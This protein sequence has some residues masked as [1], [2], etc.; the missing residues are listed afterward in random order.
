MANY[1]IGDLQ[2][3]DSAFGRL[4]GKIDFSP[5]RDTLFV[6]GDLVNRGPESLATLERL[7][8]YGDAARCLLGNHDLNLLAIA[9]GVRQPHRKDTVAAILQSPKRDAMMD[10]LKQQRLA[11][12][13]DQHTPSKPSKQPNKPLLMVHAG[14]LPNWT[15]TKTIALAG[16]VETLLRHAPE[17]ELRNFLH[18]MYGD[19]PEQWHDGLQGTPRLR[20]IV[21][22]LTRL[23][24]CTAEGVMEFA[25]KDSAYAAPVGYMPWFD[26]PKRATQDVAVAFGHWSTLGWL[27]RSDVFALDGGCVWG[28][29][30]NALRL[31]NSNDSSQTQHALIHVQCEQAQR[32]AKASEA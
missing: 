32:P 10:W 19:L 14:V 18:D 29:C 27:D 23:R 17:A 20:V 31:A 15:A 30:L 24:F 4:L 2:G 13:I 22:A 7:I 12:L 1:L 9:H 8:S 25:T 6:L 3:C 11:M 21:N 28:G 16:E 5:S 26:V